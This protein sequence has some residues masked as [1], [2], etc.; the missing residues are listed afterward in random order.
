VTHR[1]VGLTTAIVV[2]W[3][4]ARSFGIPELQM[5]AVGC[6]VL[7]VGAVLWAVLLPTRLTVERSVV[8]G[9]VWFD[10]EAVV[11]ITLRNTGR[12]STPE[13]TVR[14][15]APASLVSNDRARLAP[16]P[17]A[18]RATISYAIHGRQRGRFELGPLRILS[19]DP[20]GLVRRTR[21]IDAPGSVTVYPPVWN[22]PSGLPLGGATRTGSD[23]RRRTVSDGDDLADIRE[24]VRGDDLRSVHWP[25]TAHRGKLM[26]RRAESARSPGAVVLIDRRDD[27]HHGHGAAS[28][29]ETAI[30]A[31]ASAGY[32]LARRGRSVTL[33][34]GPVGRPPKPLP[35]EAWLEQL[36]DLATEPVDLAGL[37]RQVGD[38]M[39]G[40]GTLIAVITVPD[41][42]ELRTLVRAG[43]GF[44]TRAAVIVDASSHGSRG[45]DPRA[46]D[47]AASLR[48]AGW[49][50]TTVA[51]GER[52][53]E[54]W[55]QLVASGRG[56]REGIRSGT[57]AV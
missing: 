47:V 38:G 43:R 45:R 32:H 7:V 29:F 30:A 40:D 24:Y 44:S 18:S 37:L 57:G 20:F 15:T 23:R 39:A 31:T 36:A 54:R 4:S 48:A 52:L 56:T 51:R 49:R 41:P 8:P 55:R 14:D 1:G 2:L 50:A 10:H 11:R 6:L 19:T 28:S 26:V 46:P 17:A 22:L 3:A 27:R 16:L 9:T 33:L 34:D 12:F 42:A 25:S 5:A 35:W 21:T 53:D 13:L